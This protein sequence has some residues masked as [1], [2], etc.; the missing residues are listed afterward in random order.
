MDKKYNGK[1]AV[2]EVLLDISEKANLKFRQVNKSIIVSEKIGN[3]S[4]EQRLE[5]IMQGVTITGKVTSS[6]ENDGLPGV[7]VIVQGSVQGTVTDVEGNYN[8]EVPGEEAII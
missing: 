2:S 7:N 8:I 1:I 4:N 5:I 6:E 3:H